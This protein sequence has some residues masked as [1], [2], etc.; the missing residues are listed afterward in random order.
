M[1][2]L[3]ARLRTGRARAARDVLG[4]L[5]AEVRNDRV[6]GLAAELAFFGVLAL[7]PALIAVTSAMGS[8]EVL[9]GE[10]AATDVRDTVVSFFERVLTSEASGTIDAV[11]GLFDGRSPGLLTFGLVGALWATSRGFAAVINALDV[12][13]DLDE[14]RSYL[15][16]RGLALLFSVLTVVVA[17]V[18]LAMVVVGPLLGSGVDVA[19]T[20][21][22]G[23]TF[24]TFW[25]VFRWPVVV[26]VLV[27]WAALLFH[28]APNHRTPWRWD[29]VGA[30]VATAAWLAVTLGF[31]AYL[32]FAAGTNQVLG[33]LGGALIVLM[34]LYLLALGL[35][36]GGEVNAILAA[37]HGI[38]QPGQESSV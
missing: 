20:L 23:E 16:T 29:L 18:L 8:L 9:I 37:R 34:W 24:V 27:A 21:G 5:A 2:A 19:D 10:D 1:K 38:L 4:D 14:R 7:F 3:G 22:F 28:V 32:A 6:T 13:Y 30:I 15:R 12:V 17:V 31:R 11:E 36:V 33:A 25:T 26:A 35:L